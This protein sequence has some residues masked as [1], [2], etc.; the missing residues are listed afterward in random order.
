MTTLITT[1]RVA[2]AEA[3]RRWGW[4]A[5]DVTVKTGK[6]AVESL[7][8]T[9]AMVRGYLDFR[10]DAGTYMNEYAK[11]LA[12][13]QTNDRSKWEKTLRNHRN[14]VFLCHCKRGDFCHRLLLAEEFVT[15]AVEE[16]NMEDV[17]L[18]PETTPHPP[19]DS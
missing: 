5:I 12:A 2:D 9:W 6:K 14:I 15:F 18:I 8:P 11:I 3:W 4:T 17:Y 13:S 16:M 1:G 10:I 19:M 7:K